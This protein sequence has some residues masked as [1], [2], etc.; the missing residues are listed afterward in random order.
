[1]TTPAQIAANRRNS[2]RSTGP[3]TAAGKAAI[4][5]NALRHGLTADQLVIA[6]EDAAAYSGFYQEMRAALAPADGFEEQLVERIIVCS[7]RLRRASRI[8]ADLISS[9]MTDSYPLSSG[10]VATVFLNNRSFAAGVLMRYETE[11]D[12]ALHRALMM[13]ERR[14]AR[15]AGEIVPAPI[16]VAVDIAAEA[17]PIVTAAEV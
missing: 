3:R 15:R 16:A 9:S 14:Q 7:W 8:D 5:G 12:R 11:V 13:L 2:K 10:H 17:A 1:M 6:D 4:A